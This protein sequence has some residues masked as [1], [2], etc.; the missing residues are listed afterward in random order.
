MFSPRCST[1]G[2]CMTT[3]SRQ[4]PATS[5]TSSRAVTR[6]PASGIRGML[7]D[8]GLARTATPGY[9]DGAV[10]SAER[11]RARCSTVMRPARLY[12]LL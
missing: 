11:P 5:T 10:R 1:S 4:A 9:M 7:A 12:L 2:Q 6:S 3:A 8:H